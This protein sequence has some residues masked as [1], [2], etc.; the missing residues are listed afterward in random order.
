MGAGVLGA[1]LFLGAPGQAFGG[2]CDGRVDV[3]CQDGSNHNFGCT[4]Y[5]DAANGCQIGV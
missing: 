4:L 3:N 5:V 1:A 2:A